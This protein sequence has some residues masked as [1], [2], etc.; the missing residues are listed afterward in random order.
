M[1]NQA[2]RNT[3]QI[4]KALADSHRLRILML[5]KNGELCVCQI[6]EV[7]GLAMS[8]ISKHLSILA[9]ADLNAT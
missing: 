3:L 5:L 9:A 7:F 2:L 4:T 1:K 6:M 8:T